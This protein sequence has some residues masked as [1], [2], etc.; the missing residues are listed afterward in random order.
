MRDRTKML[1]YGSATTSVSKTQIQVFSPAGESI[2]SFNVRIQLD[3]AYS[4]L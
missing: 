2:I 4:R 3:D 1:A